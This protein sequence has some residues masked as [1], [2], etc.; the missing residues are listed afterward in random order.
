MPTVSALT[1]N[2]MGRRVK[3]ITMRGL[4]VMRPLA[5]SFSDLPGSSDVP[6]SDLPGYNFGPP[7]GG[8]P[9]LDF[10][11]LVD[12]PS[13]V[14]ILPFPGPAQRLPVDQTPTPVLTR[15]IIRPV[16]AFSC[17]YA[18]P[19][20]GCNWRVVPT[21]EDP[22]AAVLD[23]AP[24]R[25]FPDGQ[26]PIP[27]AN[28]VP[29]TTT[30]PQ[31]ATAPAAQPAAVVSNPNPSGG[32][33]PQNTV[34]TNLFPPSGVIQAGPLNVQ[35]PQVIFDPST[36]QITVRQPS[37]LDQFS[38]WLDEQ[39]IW[40]GVQNKWI[41]GSGVLLMLFFRGGSARVGKK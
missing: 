2:P 18:A 38:Q 37:T 33:G 15:P 14:R 26:I 27:P 22:C 4:G 11:V 13:P 7:P 3:S 21:A 19:P 40:P 23:C 39:T 24:G 25:G 17:D 29:V 6:L 16:P 1:S 10:P 12:Q 36:G 34:G 31:T 28:A 20:A 30:V 9:Q 32:P 5:L 8:P 41:L 35:V